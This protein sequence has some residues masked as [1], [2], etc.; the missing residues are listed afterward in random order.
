MLSLAV[1]ASN[2]APEESLRYARFLM[3]D[4][5]P[6]VAEPILIDALRLAPNN[7]EILIELGRIY[8]AQEDWAR[9]EQVEATLRR[10]GTDES[11]AAAEALLVARLQAQNR[12]DEAVAQLE[13]MLQ[14]QG[15]GA[16]AEIEIVRT[17]LRNGDAAAAEAFVDGLLAENPDAALLRFL[18][19]SILS[20][21]GR[22]PEAEALYLALLDDFPTEESLW[23]NLYS[24][25]VRGGRVDEA[26]ATLERGIEALPEAPNLQWALAGE[27]ERQGD[28]DAAIGIY[29]RL[30]QQNTNS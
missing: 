26:R 25:Q 12:A 1:E 13:A 16:G 6:G 21:T 9:L 14:Q 8:L 28:M 18:K 22:N 27:Y 4:D 20:A 23:R 17:H 11:G 29:E 2:N 10:L 5:R 24:L 3:E 15:L 30:Y 19:A 7:P